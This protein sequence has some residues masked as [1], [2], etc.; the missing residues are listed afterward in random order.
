MHLT[1]M[2][3]NIQKFRLFTPI[4]NYLITMPSIA[5]CDRYIYK[6]QGARGTI[7]KECK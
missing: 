4:Y 7:S 5:R 1:Y 3:K 2:Q 6:C